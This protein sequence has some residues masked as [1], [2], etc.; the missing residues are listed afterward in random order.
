[1][2]GTVAIL[3]FYCNCKAPTE[4][5]ELQMK[6]GMEDLEFAAYEQFK[7]GTSDFWLAIT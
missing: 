4:R 6:L 7:A 3:D 2:S 1:M 5:E